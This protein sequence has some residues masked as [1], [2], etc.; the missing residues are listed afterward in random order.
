MLKFN[1]NRRIW[2]RKD[3]EIDVDGKLSCANDDTED[4]RFYSVDVNDEKRRLP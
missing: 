2:K 4:I 1:K 3:I